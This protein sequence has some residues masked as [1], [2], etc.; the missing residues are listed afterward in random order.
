MAKQFEKGKPVWYVNKRTKKVYVGVY[1][2]YSKTEELHVIYDRLYNRYGPYITTDDCL[3]AT[4]EQAL[5]V[6]TNYLLE[7]WKNTIDLA[8]KYAD[9]RLKNRA[10]LEKSPKPTDK[11]NKA[12]KRLYAR[13]LQWTGER[14]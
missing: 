5:I 3:F 14:S 7:L 1:V 13:Y 9:Q 2:K 10:I 4:K 8:N 11:E 6:L 12:Y